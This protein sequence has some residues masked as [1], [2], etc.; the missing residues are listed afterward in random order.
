M[1][2]FIAILFDEITIQ[3][4]KAVQERFKKLGCGNFT[5]ED[6]LHLTLV[7][8]GDISQDKISKIQRI[9]DE[10]SEKSFHL[11]FDHVGRFQREG[12]D[13]WWI[14]MQQNMELEQTQYR[15][16]SKLKLADFILENRSFTPHITLV[17]KFISSEEL[18]LKHLM[19][20]MV[21]TRVTAICLMQSQRI[22]GRLIY[23]Q[24]YKKELR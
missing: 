10:V 1:R 4:I 14:G 17:R 19:G 11:A 6:N 12:G 21:T 5:V 2:L 3:N 13:I 9:I 24:L 16:S 20:Q 23:T 18:D 8:L 15:L 7:F 22:D